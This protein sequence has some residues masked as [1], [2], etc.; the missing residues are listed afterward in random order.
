MWPSSPLLCVL[1]LLLLPAVVECSWGSSS[2]L[3]DIG[4]SMNEFK[5]M[6]E[7]TE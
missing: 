7:D 2:R 4:E 5:E 3:S 6:V 1:S